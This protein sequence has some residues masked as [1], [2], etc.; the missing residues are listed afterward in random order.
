MAINERRKLNLGCGADIRHGYINLDC[1][2]A[3]GINVVWDLEKFPYPFKEGQ[4]DEIYARFILEHLDNIVKV[5]RE[6]HRILKVGGKLFIEVPYDTSYSTWSNFQHKRAYNLKT[7]PM[8]VPSAITHVKTHDYGLGFGF[9]SIKQTLWF[10]KGLHL[11]SYI[12]SPIFNRMHTIYEGTGLRALFPAYSI[13][14]EI[15]K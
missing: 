6:W 2:E 1:V 11:E 10:P 15:I 4:F 5:M 13:R 9:K 12:I 14:A 8:F 3:E 7:L